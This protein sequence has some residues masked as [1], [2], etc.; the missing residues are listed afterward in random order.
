MSSMVAKRNNAD[1]SSKWNLESGNGK[2]CG[3]KMLVWQ[4]CETVF[5]LI[6]PA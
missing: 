6:K 5:E 1:Y 2:F 4:S 3:K